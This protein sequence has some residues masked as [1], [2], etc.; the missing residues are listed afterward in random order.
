MKLGAFDYVVKPLHMDGLA[1]TIQNALETIRLKKEVQALQE[2]YLEESVPCFIGESNTIQD[3]MK[4]IRKVAQSPDTPILILGE[5]GT[6][7][8]LIASAIHY[9]SPNFKGPFMPVNCAAIPKDLVESELFGYEKG[10]FSGARVSGKKGLIEE[11]AGGTLFLDEVGDLS[12]DAQAKLLRFLEEGEFY[13]IGG[14]KKIQIQTRLV[15]ATNKDLEHMMA[16][17]LFRKDLY[18]RLGVIKLQ[19]PSLNDRAD[20]I[21]LL[22]RH[23]MFKFSCKF[24]KTFNTLSPQV[25]KAL[26]MHKW[27]GHVRELKNMIERGVLIGRGPQL[28]VADLGLTTMPA[29]TESGKKTNQPVFPPLSAEGIDLSAAMES[30][31]KTYIEEALKLADGNESKAA[32]LLKI[33]HHTFRYRR[34]KLF[35]A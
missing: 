18:F 20:D 5:T 32:R 8:E 19:I 26:T 33:N 16:N 30:M 31:E 28:D 17:E 1:V 7:K 23:F 14:T 9:R 21:L 6:G 12:L 29:A 11:A 4:F 35:S 10:A 34:K 24:E 25:E 15:S 27:T 3:V 13:R 22:A 2:K